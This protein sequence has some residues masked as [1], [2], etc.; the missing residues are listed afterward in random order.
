MKAVIWTDVL[1]SIIMMAGMVAIIVFGIVD[2]GGVSTVFKLA[3]R[4]K[5]TELE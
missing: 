5:R 3:E 2:V 1:Q 4:G